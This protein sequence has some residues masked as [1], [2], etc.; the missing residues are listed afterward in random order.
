MKNS[1]NRRMA[2]K[3]ISIAIIVVG[4][5]LLAYMVKVESEPGL[6]PLVLIITGTASYI[7]FKV[8]TVKKNS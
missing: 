7:Y 8:K 3:V 5:V 4:I 1:I 6:L 2:F